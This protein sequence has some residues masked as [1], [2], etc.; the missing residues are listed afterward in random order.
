LVYLKF[1]K[2][3][4]KTFLTFLTLA[5]FSVKSN[6]KS[7]HGNG[8]FHKKFLF[9]AVPIFAT[10]QHHL[11]DR[12]TR[13]LMQWNIIYFQTQVEKNKAKNRWGNIH[14]NIFRY[15][16]VQ[17]Y[18]YTVHNYFQFGTTVLQVQAH[19]FLAEAGTASKFISQN[20][21]TGHE[22]ITCLQFNK[23]SIFQLFH[24]NLHTFGFNF[25]F[26]LSLAM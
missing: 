19:H 18:W 11:I 22:L 7:S 20:Y 12:I 10:T 17:V 24:R 9:T 21:W 16:T 4:I 8:R 6:Y 26:K 25:S 23:F 5:F 14:Y 3:W 2:K 15:W 13:S 1:E